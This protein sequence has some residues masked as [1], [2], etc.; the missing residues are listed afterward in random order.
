MEK[1]KKEKFCVIQLLTDFED[2]RYL[3]RS[4][5][6]ASIQYWEGYSM[7][8]NKEDSDTKKFVWPSLAEIILVYEREISGF[9]SMIL[10]IREIML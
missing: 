3:A 2:A 5:K 1:E 9:F 7:A 4:V 10:E 6:L 8:I